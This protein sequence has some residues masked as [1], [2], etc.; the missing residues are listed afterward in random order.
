MYRTAVY[1]SVLCLFLLITSAAVGA[2]ATSG[3]IDGVV[4]GPDGSA[5]PGVRVVAN[6][7]AMIQ[8]DVTVYTD[9]TGRYRI[10]LLLSGT[11]EIDFSLDGFT[12]F[13]QDGVIVRVGQTTEQNARLEL[14]TV[15]ETVVVSA[16]APIIDARAAKL[17]F[18]YTDQVV[19]NI[20]VARTVNDVFYTVPGVESMN[21]YGNAAQPGVVDVQ[22]VLGAGERT[23]DYSFD[24][25]NV[26]DPAAQ[27]NIQM[28]M[29][30][31]TFEEL[32]VVK[33][34]K[35]AEIPYQGGLFNIITKSGGNDLH[36]QLGAYFTD[37]ALQS[38]NAEDI[39]QEAGVE[40]TN[41]IVGGYEATASVGGRIVR[42]KLWWFA[43]ARRQEGTSRIFGFPSDIANEITGLSGKI[44]YQ[45]NQDHRITT[46]ATGWD[47]HVSHFFFGFSPSLAMDAN[48]AADRPMYGHSIGGNWSGIL[49]EN[50]LA[51]AGLSYAGAGYDQLMQPGADEVAIV[52]LGTGQRWR[53]LGEGSRV[54]TNYN[55]SLEGSLSWF[56]PEAA[57]R[58][59]FKLGFE[60]NPTHFHQEFDDL[61]DHRLHTL[62]GQNF[63]VR[64]L[65]TP[66]TAVWDNDTTSFYLQD[67]WSLGDRLT[68]NAGLR[69]MHKN[70]TT[71]EAVVS[72]GTFAGTAVADRFPLL[73][74]HTLAATELINWNTVEPRFAM[75]F[76]LDRAGRTVL[77]AGASQ[78]HHNITAFDL[79][80]SNPAFPY[81]YVTLWFDRN[82]DSAFQVGE[83]GPLLFSFGGQINPVDP[84]IEPAYSNE[85]VVGMSHEATQNWQ[86]SANFIYR[87]DNKLWN[88]IDVG[89]PFSAYR[90]VPT[91]DPGPD[92]I[93]GT[94]DDAPLTVYAQ[95][96]STIGQSAWLLT[97]PEGSDRTYKGLE[98][99]AS[100]R[101][102]DNWQA[103]ASLVVSELEVIKT[104]GANETSG[105][106]DT[107][108][109]LIYARGLDP[110]N[111]P[112]QLKLQGIYV[113][114]FGLTASGFYR[115][116]SGNP[117]TR[118]LTVTSLP[119]GPITVFAEPRGS[120][121]TDTA[122]IFDLRFEQNIRVAS[123]ARIGLI[124]DVFNLLNSAAVG[125]YGTLTGIDYAQPRAIQNPRLV[126]LGVRFIF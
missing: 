118:E 25:A 19:E 111:I 71:P 122:N 40:S 79:F 36:G 32:Q 22:N 42:D 116:A 34:A 62:F 31:D 50:V 92:G 114:D 96:P 63:A 43:S 113:F 28:L 124:L 66:S 115:L 59:D 67:T 98:I 55:V 87:K 97:N 38:S 95:D 33:S 90:P 94:S 93:P 108:N 12:S 47:Q 109:D 51:E 11:Y 106:F 73:N 91:L 8:K 3:T 107:P 44:T 85:F 41:E 121:R 48:A 110:N 54:V 45:P 80:V 30:F 76:A 21:N 23:N 75:T 89:V 86:V 5:L 16:E 65:S 99:T 84:N 35:P 120:S 64:F 68:I 14:A 77:R 18:T 119:Q 103:V 29:P 101:L 61:E 58:H 69:F 24:G 72:G 27:W 125:D 46:T 83:D 10:P 37:D 104:T 49:T 15:S 7:P 6:S 102:S 105:V 1:L 56:V 117:Y 112:V 123:A 78:Y 4:H 2:Q 39:R 57:G 52:D 13:S 9:R 70:V 126:R 81:N 100:R 53:N 74:E 88:T 60:Y 26:A 82:Q 20:P 17:A